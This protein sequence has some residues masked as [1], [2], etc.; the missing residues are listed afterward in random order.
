MRSKLLI[1]GLAVALLGVAGCG[2]SSS[3]SST[4]AS[5]GTTPASTGTTPASTGTTPAKQGHKVKVVAVPSRTYSVKLT[6]PAEVPAG[7]PKGL[8][9]ALV[10]IH[11]K[12]DEVCWRFSR[13]TGVAGP[14]LYAH[15]HKGAKGTA[16]NVVV[17]LPG[18]S[19]QNHGC[20]PA[21]VAIL[22]A[23]EADP[24]GYYVNIHTK[25]YPGGAVRAQL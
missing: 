12:T 25:K 19:Y 15:I 24:H 21:S 14:Y 7:A 16:G 5:T 11:G 2:S 23:I 20:V 10:K 9:T 4:P 22:K 1:A 8:G 18:S 6:G 17:P 3:S 13:L